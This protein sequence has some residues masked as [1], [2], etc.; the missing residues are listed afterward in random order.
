MP[1]TLR[2]FCATA[3]KAATPDFAGDV[4]AVANALGAKPAHGTVGRKRDTLD[5]VGFLSLVVDAD[6][7][8][9]LAAELPAAVHSARLGNAAPLLRLHV[10][11]TEVSS[12]S[13]PDL[14]AALFAATDCR[15]GP[16]PWA[17]DSDPA[18]RAATISSALA[19]LPAG[20]FG[21]FGTWAYELGNATLCE[22]WPAPAGGASLSTGPLPNVPGLALSGG[23]DMRT[24]TASAQSVIAQFPQGT[25]LVVPGVGHSVALADPSGCALEA[26]HNWMS[27]AAA[28]GQCPRSPFLVAPLAALPKPVKHAG[29]RT[30]FAIADKTVREAEAAWLIASDAASPV[31]VPGLAGGT[32]TVVGKDGFRLSGYALVPGVTLSGTIKLGERRTVALDFQGAVTVAGAAAPKGHLQLIASKLSGTVGGHA[33]P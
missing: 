8:P 23:F 33:V 12:F 14:S 32:L 22:A 24:P 15:D 2:A 7:S 4:V 6:L 9:G 1:A 20:S 27:G 10:L 29:P 13:A 25:L 17:P 18:S 31:P 26:V 5:G 19:A 16:F 28:I 21:P 30:A 11:D 3:C